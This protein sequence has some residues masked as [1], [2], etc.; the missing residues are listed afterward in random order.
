MGEENCIL[1]QIINGKVPSKKIYEDEN[2]LAI[3]DVNGANA[4]HCFVIPKK[5]YPILE[6]IPD[7]ELA[8]LFKVANAVSSSIFETLKVEGTNI[9]VSN[10]VAAGQTVAHFMIN[11]IPRRQGDGINL[12]W[13]PKQIGEEE[14]STVEIK[15]RAET[16]SGH[17]FGGQEPEETTK[18]K[19]ETE[20]LIG[21]DNYLIKQLRRIP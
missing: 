5:H 11:V 20:V 10:G 9:F 8:A 12:E 18:P 4:G 6:Q 7:N 2:T 1:C 3:L 14:M 17:Q 21:E 13:Q 16:E 15:L 19:E